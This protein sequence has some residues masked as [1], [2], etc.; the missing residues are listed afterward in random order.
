MKKKERTVFILISQYLLKF[1]KQNGIRDYIW[2]KVSQLVM[3][4]LGINH[5]YM[6]TL[7]PI[8]KFE[9]YR[10]LVLSKKEVRITETMKTREFIT[11]IKIKMTICIDQANLAQNIYFSDDNFCRNFLALPLPRLISTNPFAACSTLGVLF[12]LSPQSS[13]QM[14]LFVLC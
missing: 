6:S 11:Q 10:K 7:V 8:C 1:G 5:S 12:C 9:K 2:T 4:A 3:L 14:L 13:L